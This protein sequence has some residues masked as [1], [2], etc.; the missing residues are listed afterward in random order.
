MTGNLLVELPVDRGHC[1]LIVELSGCA[2]SQVIYWDRRGLGKVYWLSAAE[3]QQRLGS[4][5]FGPDALIVTASM[6]RARMATIRRDIKVA[7]L[8]QR[9]VAGIGNLYASEILHVAGIDPRARCDSLDANS[10]RRL[11][12]AVQRVLN[13]AVR[14]EGSTLNDGTYRNS[15]SH[16]GSYQS[17]HRV[18][19]RTGEAC[20]TCRLGKIRR[21]VQAQRATFYCDRCQK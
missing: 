14:Y 9:L 10:W 6:L 17:Q 11:H 15:V 5:Y 20:P 16:P 13:A 1:R 12:R 18:Y 3:A 2:T 8:D 7:L 21:I 4:D 19:Q